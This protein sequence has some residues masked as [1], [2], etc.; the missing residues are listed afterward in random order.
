MR[1]CSLTAAAASDCATAGA[2][3]LR[4]RPGPIRRLKLRLAL[5]GSLHTMRMVCSGVHA[6][7]IK[8]HDLRGISRGMRLK[9]HALSNATGTRRCFAEASSL[10]SECHL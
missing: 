6:F 10:P 5:P 3:F 2:R 7:S 8:R 9:D 4:G 1:G